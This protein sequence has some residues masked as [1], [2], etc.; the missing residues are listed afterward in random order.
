MIQKLSI[1]NYQSHTDTELELGALTVL[2]G[3]SNSGKSAV[4]RAF[5]ALAGNQTGKDFITVGQTTTQISATTDQGTIVLTKGKPED[6][7]VILP[8]DDPKNP[9]RFTKLGVGVPQDVTDFLGIEPKDAINFANQLDM[10]YLLKTSSAEVARVLG[11]LT[12]VS[13][14]FEASREALRRARDYSGKLKTREADLLTLE[15]QLAQFETLDARAAALAAA[16]MYFNAAQATTQ[17]AHRLDDLL[18]TLKIATSRLKS[19]SEATSAPLPDVQASV[20]MYGRLERLDSL[21]AALKAGGTALKNAQTS[22]A[23]NE[24]TIISLDFEY[25]TILRDAGTCPTCGQNTEGVHAHA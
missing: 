8:A 21:L 11:E 3:P 22:I 24:D 7:Y 2:V 9:K 25:E 16:E 15:P 10:P 19:A 4:V 20:D 14:I 18:A 1:K 5:R 6:S 12:N 13:S 17:Q 23:T